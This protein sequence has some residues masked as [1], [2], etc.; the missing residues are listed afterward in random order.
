MFNL[1]YIFLIFEQL[2]Q[3]KA[4][5]KFPLWKLM[6]ALPTSTASFF[7]NKSGS[8]EIPAIN[9]RKPSTLY[10]SIRCSK[11]VFIWSQ[12]TFSGDRSSEF[13]KKSSAIGSV[14]TKKDFLNLSYPLLYENYEIKFS[15]WFK[16]PYFYLVLMKY[17]LK[18]LTK[19][20][21]L[22]ILE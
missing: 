10:W 15:N 21:K 13:S 14:T 16:K 20:N 5:L 1:I 12:L 4:N 8:W 6:I 18:Y 17:S 3:N 2:T 19:F 9:N 22:R 7:S 11:A